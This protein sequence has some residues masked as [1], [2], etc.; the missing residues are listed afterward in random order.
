M[1]LF[2]IFLW[3]PVQQRA[4]ALAASAA[5]SESQALVEATAE[6]T[7]EQT[8]RITLPRRFSLPMR[9]VLQLQ[10]RFVDRRPRRVRSLLQH[11]RFRAAYD[12][13][14]LRARVGEVEQEL[15]DFWTAAQ[16]GEEP[17]PTAAGEHR[18][19]RRRRRPRRRAGNPSPAV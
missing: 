4:A 6:I 7:L 9:E 18:A 15:A 3:Q 16:Q 14:L 11:K 5:M 1:F 2:A 17:P 19:R 10:R 8:G 12:L 13:M